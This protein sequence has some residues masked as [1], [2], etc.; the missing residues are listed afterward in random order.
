MERAILRA[1]PLNRQSKDSANVFTT[2]LAPAR[3][4]MHGARHER[5]ARDTF[6]R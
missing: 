3:A 2:R 1:A 4:R 6:R 5:R